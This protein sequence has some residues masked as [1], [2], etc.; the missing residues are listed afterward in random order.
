MSKCMRKGKIITR[1]FPVRKKIDDLF[2]YNDHLIW[3]KH[4]DLEGYIVYQE[5]NDLLQEN[6]TMT[7]AQFKKY[8]KFLLT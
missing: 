7:P 8:R 2:I 1:T 6:Q 3:V 5:A 4:E